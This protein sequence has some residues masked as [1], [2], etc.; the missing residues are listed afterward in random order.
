M[1]TAFDSMDGF[2]GATCRLGEFKK[3]IKIPKK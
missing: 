2:E 1:I 3:L